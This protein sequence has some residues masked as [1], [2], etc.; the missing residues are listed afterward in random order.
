MLPMADLHTPMWYAAMVAAKRREKEKTDA[1][2]IVKK[3]ESEGAWA[4]SGFV[5]MKAW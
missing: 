1:W 5:S 4:C 2:E 3:K